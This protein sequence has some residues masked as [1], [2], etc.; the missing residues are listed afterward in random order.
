ML[1]HLAELVDD[2]E[3]A[4]PRALVER[5]GRPGHEVEDALLGGLRGSG[6][7]GEGLEVGA[8]L[9]E[10]VRG[11]TTPPAVVG[12]EGVE[13]FGEPSEKRREERL[14]RADD[15]DGAERPA[16]DAFEPLG[17]VRR[18]LSKMRDGGAVP[19]EEPAQEEGERAFP[20]A[21]G[22]RDRPRALSDGGGEGVRDAADEFT[23]LGGDDVAVVGAVSVDVAAEVDAS[24]E[25][26]SDRDGHGLRDLERGV[27]TAQEVDGLG[28]AEAVELLEAGRLGVAERGVVGRLEPG[29]EVEGLL[30][31]EDEDAAWRAR[32]VEEVGD[33][34]GL[35]LGPGPAPVVEDGGRKDARGKR[36]VG[37]LS[38]EDEAALVG[39]EAELGERGRD[40][41]FGVLAGVDCVGTD[42]ALEVPLQRAIGGEVL[43]VG[44]E[45]RVEG[46]AEAAEIERA[47]GP[48]PEHE[49]PEGGP[50][51]V[52]AEEPV[53][54]PRGP[55]VFAVRIGAVGP[56]HLVSK[57]RRGNAPP[58]I[59]D[60]DVGSQ[61][62]VADGPDHIAADAERGDGAV[63][64]EH[65]GVGPRCLDGLR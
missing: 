36:G 27:V 60:E 39:D 15:E 64:L 57:L 46:G 23:G 43:V 22:S 49:V 37:A 32:A 16:R 56:K 33:G 19:A 26:A 10:L 4:A 18:L 20:S 40:G 55:R 7:G 42:E 12:D 5:L 24:A 47:A 59:G 44:L 35:G 11:P 41:V 63:V 45:P 62:P 31:G 38:E 28:V 21:V 1:E 65:L 30:V 29:D 58:A 17:E 8:E 61:A 25:L 2:E 13:P 6:F 14:A 54:E 51:G 9:L 50:G 48:V 53:E 34:E 3:D 52:T